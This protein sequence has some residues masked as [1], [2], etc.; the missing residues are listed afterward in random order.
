MSN[1]EFERLDRM[2]RLEMQLTLARWEQIMDEFDRE[3]NA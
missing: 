2:L 3:V 1:A